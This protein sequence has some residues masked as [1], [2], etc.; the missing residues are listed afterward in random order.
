MQHVRSPPDTGHLGCAGPLAA[1]R[2]AARRSVH[3]S[4]RARRRAARGH[5]GGRPPQRVGA[6]SRY[7]APSSGASTAAG[8]R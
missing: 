8:G 6:N 1:S 5:E 3:A 2:I 4:E 7:A